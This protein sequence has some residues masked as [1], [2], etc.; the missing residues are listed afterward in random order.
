VIERDRFEAKVD[1][2]GRHHLWT[3]S[4]SQQGVG[5]IRIDGK[6]HTAPRIAWMLAFGDLPPG[7]R[8]LCCPDEPACVRPDHLRLDGEPLAPMS[9]RANRGGGTISEISP[10]TWKVGVSVGR[11]DHGQR[12]RVFRSIHGTK[13]DAAR[14]LAALRTEIGDGTRLANRDD[15]TLTLDELI[16]WYV[17]FARDDRGLEHS[18][19]T[20]YA[21][22]YD[23]WIRKP[24]GHRRAASVRPADLDA[25]FGVMRRAG[26][27][28][29]RMNNARALLSG[30][31]KWGKRHGKVS[32]NPADGFELPTSLHSPRPTNTP[33]LADLLQLLDGAEQH[34]P[35]LAPV[36]KLG[37]TTGMRRGELAG[38]R[39]D[40]LRLDRNELV[41]DTSINDAGGIVIEKPTKTNRRRL[42][43]IDDAT[44]TMLRA[45][46]A[47]MDERAAFCRSTVPANGFVFSLDPTCDVP[48]RP[49]FMTRRTRLLRAKLRI[50]P[51][52]FDATIL[53]LRRWT[54]TELMDAGFNPS[55][56]S[57]RQG[58]TVQVMLHHYSSRRRSADRAAAEHLGSRV[59]RGATASD[60]TGGSQPG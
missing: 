56:V 43:S 16:A 7:A 57:D 12:R 29:S 21:D 4:R 27:S 28:R 45:H 41:V 18:T 55:A 44:A 52:D 58:H 19:L 32:A 10:G 1:R 34:D 46:L 11:D 6:L 15:R 25:A 20:G 17:A 54:T 51:G 37:A 14:E 53:A 26:L 23:H 39:R 60:S 8:V 47:E 22:V 35:I 2:S 40:R 31:Y 59:H 50:A 38:L 24:L 48:M 49:E 33:E 30:A 42:V 13:A 3:G 5:Q 36:L 9:R